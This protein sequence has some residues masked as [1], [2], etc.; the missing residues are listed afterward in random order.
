MTNYQVITKLLILMLS[1]VERRK[2]Y[3]LNYTLIKNKKRKKSD[4]KSIKKNSRKRI[5]N[6]I[7][8]YYILRTVMQQ[9]QYP[10]LT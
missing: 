7:C 8:N 1:L 2:Q 5:R 6:K 9:Q 3:R 10:W 4:C